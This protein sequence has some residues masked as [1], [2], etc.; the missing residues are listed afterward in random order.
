MIWSHDIS[1]QGFSFPPVWV[2]IAFQCICP[3]Q[4]W[5][6]QNVQWCCSGGASFTKSHPVFQTP[7][8]S[9]FPSSGDSC[10][11]GYKAVKGREELILNEVKKLRPLFKETNR[12]AP[13]E[14]TTVRKSR[15]ESTVLPL[16]LWTKNC[17]AF[18]WIMIGLVRKSIAPLTELATLLI[19]TSHT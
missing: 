7:I 11:D 2:I 6:K 15:L 13:T 1:W 5:E 8:F 19:C 17:S 9:F 12:N 3:R 16:C 14:Q 18:Y 4:P 10:C